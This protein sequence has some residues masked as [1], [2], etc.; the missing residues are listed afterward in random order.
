MKLALVTGADG[1]LGR[2]LQRAAWPA[3]WEVVAVN[4]A[5]LDLRDPPAIAAVI[6]SRPWN[7]VINAGAFTAVDKA[8]T[9]VVDA[10]TI[11]ALA[12]AVLA[13]ASERAGIPIVQI[14]TDYVFDGT[15]EGGWNVG[16]PTGPLCVYGASKLGGELAVATACRRHVIIRTAWMVS[17]H[18]SNFVKTMLRLGAECSK[19]RVVDDQRGSPTSARDLAEAVS[20]IAVRLT[21]D[22]EAPTGTYHFSNA[23]A[24]TWYGFA[25]AIFD[26]AARRGRQAPIVEPIRTID[27]PTA[28]RRP[29]NSE[30]AHAAILRDYGI[31]PRPWPTALD[32]L[33]DELIG[34]SE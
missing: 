29:R 14:S 12:P 32:D 3:G 6:A 24:V 2:E 9:Q 22:P 21:D 15:Q 27:Y 19:V 31:A 5:A 10:W 26:A 1:Q 18:G 34:V 17:P 30:L 28:A 23:G 25:R 20:I 33:L 13:A 7:V 8:E 16:D 4:R 11:N